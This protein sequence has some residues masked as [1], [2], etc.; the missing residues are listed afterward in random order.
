VLPNPS[1]KWTPNSLRLFVYRPQVLVGMAGRPVVVVNGRKMLTALTESMLEPGSVFIVDAPADHTRVDWIQFRNA[2]ASSNPLD[3]TGL[4]GATRYLRWTLK[5]TY[6]YLEPVSEDVARSE[7]APLR[8]M[9][10]RNLLAPPQ[11]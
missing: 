11:Q 9:G 10:Y 1:L 4:A 7:I 5:P 2:E 3:F 6:G 8:Y